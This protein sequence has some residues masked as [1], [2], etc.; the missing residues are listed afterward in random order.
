MDWE[1]PMKE[2]AWKRLSLGFIAFGQ[3]N[4]SR[5]EDKSGYDCDAIEKSFFAFFI[6]AFTVV[7]L[8][9]FELC[10]VNDQCMNITPFKNT[11]SISSV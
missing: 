7:R 3:A 4:A 6:Y 9:Q 1:W 8:H 10:V 2:K 5:N 11:L